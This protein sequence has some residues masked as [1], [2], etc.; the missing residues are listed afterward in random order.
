M[1]DRGSLESTYTRHH[2][3]HGRHNFS[4][5]IAERG[6]QFAGWIGTG[7]RVLDLGCRDGNLTQYYAADND[8]TGVDIDQQALALA[9]QR[10]G[11]ETLWLDLNGAQFP[12]VDGSFDAV[13]AGE[14]MEHLV[15]PPA[16]VAGIHR[17]LAPGG[18]FVGSVPNSFHWRAR[19]AFLRGR[20]I[21]DPTHLQL[22]S[23]LRV[24][25]TLREFATV[26][27]L[28][29]GGIGGGV[30]PIVPARLSQAIIHWLPTWFANDFLFRA[31]KGSERQL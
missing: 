29:V 11:I 20:T 3:E 30:L 9:R 6:P 15:D 19:L 13:V 5:R 4:Y 31:I 22:F 2:V 23:L 18:V 10:L 16:I 26:E 17:V 14:L 27:V 25:A 21:E 8:V 12:F 24:H 1:A 28:P 7:K